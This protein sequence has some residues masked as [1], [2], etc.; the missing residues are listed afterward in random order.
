MPN[1]KIVWTALPNGV[2]GANADRVL[3]LSVFV[4]PRL[5]EGDQLRLWPIL[6]D[7]TNHIGDATFKVTFERP[8]GTTTIDAKRVGEAL[9]PELWRALF[10]PDTFVHP[11][12]FDNYSGRRIIS[13]PARRVHRAVKRLYQETGTQAPAGIA[14]A[15]PLRWENEY[16]DL[17]TGNKPNGAVLGIATSG[18][19]IYA[20]HF[21]H[22]L[23]NPD[24]PNPTPGGQVVKIDSESRAIVAQVGVGPA[25]QSL[26]IMPDKNKPGRNK[27]YFLSR[28]PGQ[29]RSANNLVDHGRG[30]QHLQPAA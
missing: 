9:E 24:D 19:F 21:A 11:H 5:T 22:D 27:L 2:S 3:N 26:A 17:G 25:P 8:G 10:K 7:W 16:I 20:T 23:Q 6:A 13:Y 12:V 1:Q 14:P 30:R 4:A 18:R 28:I 15:P 29:P